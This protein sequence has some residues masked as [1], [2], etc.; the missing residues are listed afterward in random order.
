MI[1]SV[2]IDAGGERHTLKMGASAMMRLED[3]FDKSVAGIVDDIQ[4]EQRIGTII[5]VLAECM[6]DGKGCA[7]DAASDLVDVL[8]I[9]GAGEALGKVAEAAFPDAKASD[10]KDDVKNG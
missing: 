2:T 10:D 6:N 8:G 4:K 1:S 7:V 3:A 9:E 5:R